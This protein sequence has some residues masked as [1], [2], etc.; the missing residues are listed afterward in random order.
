VDCIFCKIVAREIPADILYQDGK[1]TAF[2]DVTPQ[3]PT[4]V[5]IVPNEH[6]PDIH[7]ATAEQL[8]VLPCMANAAN[9]VAEQEGLVGRGFR[10]VINQGPEAGQEVS[11]LHLHL[12]GGRRFSW[13]PG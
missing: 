13:P 7:Q 6:I 5:L 4:H 12:L 11:H 3:A 8:A 1:V 2:R 10:L 9:R